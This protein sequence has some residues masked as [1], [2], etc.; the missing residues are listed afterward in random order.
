MA[1]VRTVGEVVGAVGAHEQLE[2]KRRLV[3]RPAGGVELGHVGIGQGVKR[4]GDTLERRVPADGDIGIGGRIIDHR[5]G[6]PTEIFDIVV[7]PGQKLG[8]RVAR[9]DL[10]RGALLRGFPGDGLG[11]V[12]AEFEGRGVFGI[13]PGATRAVEAVGLVFAQQGFPGGH[14]VHLGA[15]GLGHGL[16]RVPAAGGVGV[17]AQAAVLVRCIVHAGLSNHA[18]HNHRP[19]APASQA[20]NHRKTVIAIPCEAPKSALSKAK[21][22]PVHEALQFSG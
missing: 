20:D 1:H 8:H 15:H 9:E 18:E 4:R 2:Q 17:D 19:S 14:G 11:A 13:R 7:V 6:Q 3:R 5:V 21:I 22:R 12:L 16:E 10:G